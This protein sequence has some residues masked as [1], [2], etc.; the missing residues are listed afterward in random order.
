[1]LFIYDFLSNFFFFLVLATDNEKYARR[2]RKNIL[3]E[4]RSGKVKTTGREHNYLFFIINNTK[5]LSMYSYFET[6]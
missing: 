6:C 3:Y 5:N 4:L 2:K 1:M